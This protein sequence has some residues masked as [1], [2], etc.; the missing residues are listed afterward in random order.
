MTGVSATKAFLLTTSFRDARGRL[1]ITLYG[2]T[3][4]GFPLRVVVDN[5][6]PLFFVPRT[7]ADSALP[8]AAERRP[9]PLKSLENQAVDCLYFSSYREYVRTAER[10][11]G[12]GTPVFESDINP[13]DRYLMERAVRGGF[14]VEGHIEKRGGYVQARNPRIRGDS[15]DVDLKVMSL[16]IETNVDTGEIYSIACAGSRDVVFVREMAGDYS[17]GINCPDEQSLLKAFLEHVGKEDPDIL[18]G[19]NVIDFDLTVIQNRC[20]HLSIP[21][22]LGRKGT[23]RILPSSP[24]HKFSSVRVPGRV[25]LDIP[26]MLRAQFH[27]YEEYSLDHVASCVLG[28][29]KLIDKTGKE[30]IAEINRL[31]K[32]DKA[33][34]AR[35]NLEDARLA[36]EI[37]EKTGLLPN[38]VE[39]SR[40]SGH[41]LDRLGGSVAAFDYLYLPLLHRMGYVAKTTLDVFPSDRPLPGGYVMDSVPGFH[42]NVLVFDFKSLYPSL[43]RTFCIDPLGMHSKAV[44]RVQGPVGPSFSVK[45]SLLPEIIGKLMQARA[46]AKEVGNPHLSQAIKILMNS[47][48]GVLG[49]PGCRFFSYDLASTIT[50]TGRFILRKTVAYI[51]E[52][53]G[54]KAVY[55]DTDSLFVHAGA[56]TGDEAQAIGVEIVG[57]VNAWLSVMLK[58]DYG[59]DSALE[60]EFETH[61]RHFFMPTL[62]GSSQGSKK[63][64]CG[65]IKTPDGKLELVFKGLESARTDWTELSREFQ[66]DLYLRVFQDEPVEDFIR[67]TVLKIRRGEVDDK[68]VYRKRLNKPLDQYTGAQ[69]PHVQAARLLEVAPRVIRYY[70]TLDGPQPVGKVHAPFD[71]EHYIQSQIQPIAESIIEWKGLRF[72][73]IVS[74]Q[75]DLFDQ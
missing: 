11:R 28:R 2:K 30:K 37:F 12:Q 53:F 17:R 31:F 46:K 1:E 23:A 59:V 5:F 29:Q 22:L 75:Q 74:G 32:E 71:Y 45:E 42:D 40:L 3:E 50:E 25:V 18:I 24:Q 65:A 52:T 33:A 9:L 64:Y 49:T 14:R 57:K 8:G 43:I 58:R 66:K 10:L 60:L 21:F 27:T 36:L 39:R 54:K 13:V 55:G 67:E 44:P 26:T 19:W 16:D 69:P 4:D 6:R 35:Y 41:L 72:E 62:R 73:S 20:D 63:R 61:F 70:I 68:L 34:L 51:E 56:V 7:V 38:A 47:F 48:Y 15:V